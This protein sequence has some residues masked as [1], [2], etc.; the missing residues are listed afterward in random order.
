[1]KTSAILNKN[2]KLTLLIG[3]LIKTVLEGLPINAA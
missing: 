3:I 2:I 1:V